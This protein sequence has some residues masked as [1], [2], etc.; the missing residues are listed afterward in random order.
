MTIIIV[1]LVWL[2][3]FLIFIPFYV[4]SHFKIL[5]I[6]RM[7]VQS[8]VHA[9]WTSTSRLDPTPHLRFSLSV[10][11]E[12]FNTWEYKRAWGHV[13]TLRVDPWTLVTTKRGFLCSSHSPL[14]ASS[15]DFLK[16]GGTN[17]IFFYNSVLFLLLVPLCLVWIH[18]AQKAL[19]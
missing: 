3:L 4:F 9:W 12:Y 11:M 5:F 7:L 8:L 18:T 17:G 15:R 19:S 16:T 10:G 14:F 2:F 13:Y 1:D 6:L